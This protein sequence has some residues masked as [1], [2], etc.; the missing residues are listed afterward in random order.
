MNKHLLK[1]VPLLFFVMAQGMTLA[2]DGSL[3]QGQSITI[4]GRVIGS[5]NQEPLPG[6]S[7]AVKGTA[8]GTLTDAD[9]NYTII[10]LAT[11]VLVFSS[12]GYL[13]QEIQ[14]SQRAVINLTLEADATMLNEVVVAG[15]VIRQS[16]LTGAVS[17][18]DG[19][20]LAEIPTAS[21]AQAMTGRMT[22]VLV[23]NNPGVSG[24]ASI[25]VRGNNSIQFGKD[26]IYVVDGL[27]MDGGINLINPNDIETIDVLKDASSTAIYG[28][29]GANGVVI[30]TTKKGKRGE[31]KITYDGWYGFQEFA[32]TVP[33]MGAKDIFDLRVDAYANAYIDANPGGNRQGYIDNVLLNESPGIS[34]FADYEFETYNSGRSYNW[35]DAVTRSGAQQNHTVSFS[36]G[37]DEGS[38]YI[39]FN[40]TRNRGLMENSQY[41]RFGGKVNIEQNVK[42]W[43]KIGTSSAYSRSHEKY[44]EGSVFG[45]ANRANPLLPLSDT[46]TYLKWGTNLG[47]DDYNP[48]KS[49]TIDGDGYQSRL[50]SSNYMNIKLAKGLNFR[51]TYAVDLMDTK[52]LWYLPM[53][54]GQSIR[55]STSGKAQHRNDHYVNWQWDNTLTYDKTFGDVHDVT[56]MIG[57]STQ[58]NNWDFN[59]I[60]VQGFA[61]DDLSYYDL[62]GASDKED[63]YPRSDFV[64]NTLASFVGR[65]NYAYSNKYFA[66]VTARY[67]GSSKFTEENRWG[68]FPSIGLGWSLSE[69]Q[70]FKNLDL[71]FVDLL[72]FNVG[73]GIAGNQNVPN[74]AYVSM[75]RPTFTNNSV[76]Y[77]SD[78]R[79]GNPDLVWEKQKQLDIGLQAA[80]LNNKVNVTANYFNIVNED[81]IMVRT[82]STTTGFYNVVANVGTLENK[83]I[84]IGVSAEILNSNGLVWRVAGNINS[85]NNKVTKLFGD[86]P[87]IYNKGGFTGVEIQ[88]EGNLFLGESLNSI[89][90]IKFDKIAQPEDVSEIHDRINFEDRIVEAGDVVPLDYNQDGFITDDDRV[91]VGKRDPKFYGG[92]STDV[93]Y[94]GISLNAVFTYNVGQKRISYLYEGLIGGTGESAAHP[95]MLNRWTPE[96]TDT[97]I[98]RATRTS[99]RYGVWETDWSVQDASFLRLSALT[100]AYT[101]PGSI[102]ER[103]KLGNLRIYF[104]GSNLFV[105][106]KYKGYDPEGG[107]SY[108]MS[109]MFVTGINI[110]F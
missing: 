23:Q 29:R 43:L 10:A 62:G 71:N 88:R 93:S 5:D 97:N 68:L 25:K 61:T 76:T 17:R 74:Y 98:P 36:K 90:A 9:G 32:N 47:L 11:D 75:Y 107:D 31:G 28:S 103:A 53:N 91:I 51:S 4:T 38:Y 57:F 89:Y 104:T 99:G 13:K 105:A 83:G 30:V 85:A 80:V 81:L 63:F 27:I 33:R 69:E 84:E 86:V 65:V 42:P 2:A 95:D 40:Y 106:T 14:V 55:N 78:G 96:N 7:V 44:V 18:M 101:F 35:L 20:Q 34:P 87:A 22:G 82:L 77:V 72:K 67:D 21:L 56:A 12:I 59:Q 92:F 45:I 109:R 79:L 8:Q 110:S 3:P 26:P 50:M 48:I 41:E 19:D 94:K 24:G 1:I 70:F 108:P 102:T 60:D 64:T 39:S 15:A 37:S 54:I 49:L 66:T 73:Y 100:L 6:V 58:R 16:E 52:D 46:L